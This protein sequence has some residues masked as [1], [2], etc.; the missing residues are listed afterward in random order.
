MSKDK[1]KVMAIN[2]AMLATGMLML[3]YASVPLYNLFCRVTGFGGTTQ[4]AAV[5]PTDIREREVEVHFDSNVDVNLDWSFE[6][7]QLSTRVKVGENGI[8]TY[9]VKNNSDKDVVGMA[10]Y[11]VTPLKTGK[12]FNKV[13]CFCF[14]EQTIKAG[15]EVHFPVSFFVEPAFADDKYMDDVDTITLSYT[16]FES[17]D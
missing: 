8:A 15:Q 11:N 10:T 13:Y 6:P 7:D 5:L 4:T 17:V 9:T 3:A 12:Y 16:F 2:L 14:E 1:N